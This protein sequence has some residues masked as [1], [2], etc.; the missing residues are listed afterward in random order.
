LSQADIDRAREIV[1]SF[2]LDRVYDRDGLPDLSGALSTFA[3]ASGV[4]AAGE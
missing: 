4:T 2:G 3:G 1:A